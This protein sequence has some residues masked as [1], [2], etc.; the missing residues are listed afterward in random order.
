MT[1]ST[2]IVDR[3]WHGRVIQ[4]YADRITIEVIDETSGAAI[5][6]TNHA[7]AFWTKQP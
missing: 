2:K 7:N 6:I 1:L 3:I 4:T 5:H